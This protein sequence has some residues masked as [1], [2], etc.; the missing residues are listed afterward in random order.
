M[1]QDGLTVV[2]E[3]PTSQA[4]PTIPENTDSS[5]CGDVPA[6]SSNAVYSEEG[7]QVV[8]NGILYENKWYTENQSPEDF[9]EF[10]WSL[11]TVLGPCDETSSV[12]ENIED[13]IEEDEIEVVIEEDEIEVVIEE[14]DEIEVVIDEETENV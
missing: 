8:Q 12:S 14:E 6:W 3:V 11:W 5:S 9:S 4:P 7:T 2:A 10:S 13:N 1:N